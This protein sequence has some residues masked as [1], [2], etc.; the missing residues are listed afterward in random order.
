VRL[1]LT[2]LY[3]GLV[4][5][6]GAA[7]LAIT[8]L[9]VR[10]ASAGV[11]STHTYGPVRQAK[12]STGLN[13]PLPKLPAL[14]QLQRQ[15]LAR[16]HTSD[17]HQLLVWSGI[18]L[19]LMALVSIALGWLIAGRVLWPLRSMTATTRRIYRDRREA[20]RR[21]PGTRRRPGQR[22]RDAAG[23]DDRERNR[24]CNPPQPA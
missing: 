7:L 19:A 24:Q 16:Q 22:Q 3:G 23:E 20:N 17:L 5:A 4:V 21:A 10:P 6:S 2:W 11:I 9:L 15:D 14:Q 12:P 13:V 1:R 18:A 8:Y